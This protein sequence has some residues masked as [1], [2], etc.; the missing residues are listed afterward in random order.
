MVQWASC[1]WVLFTYI[2]ICCGVPL[3]I[4]RSSACNPVG[5]ASRYGSEGA[6]GYSTGFFNQRVS[7]LCVGWTAPLR[8]MVFCGCIAKCKS[9]WSVLWALASNLVPANF[10][11]EGIV[12]THSPSEFLECEWQVIVFYPVNAN[13][14]LPW[15]G[16]E[17]GP[18]RM[19]VRQ[20]TNWAIDE[21]KVGDNL[22]A[23][24]V[25]STQCHTQIDSETC[26]VGAPHTIGFW[27]SKLQMDYSG[28]LYK[29]VQRLFSTV[30]FHFYQRSPPVTLWLLKWN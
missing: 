30:M 16:I 23:L 3:D 28:E 21:L 17:P 14:K 13:N 11:W 8:C 20:Q 12:R 10:F 29:L 25:S 5:D 2:D 26:S 19:W 1:I 4:Q 27:V 18:L 7:F 22:T 15:L 6:H 24:T 9:S